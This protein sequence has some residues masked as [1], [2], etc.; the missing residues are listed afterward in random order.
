MS[1]GMSHE[2][3]SAKGTEICT[4]FGIKDLA[5]HSTFFRK[6]FRCVGCNKTMVLYKTKCTKT[7]TFTMLFWCQMHSVSKKHRYFF[8]YNLHNLHKEGSL[9]PPGKPVWKEPTSG[10]D[11]SAR[12]AP[13]WI[14]GFHFNDRGDGPQKLL[15][16]RVGFRQNPQTLGNFTFLLW[17]DEPKLLEFAPFCFWRWT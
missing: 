6:C 9:S 15:S 7:L 17:G 10:K 14:Y 11:R 8:R 16:W 3:H 4:A 1:P 13:G 12:T 5:R 2:I